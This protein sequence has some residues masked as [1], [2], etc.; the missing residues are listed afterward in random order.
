MPVGALTMEVAEDDAELLEAPLGAT[1]EE[2][3]VAVEATA[4][5]GEEK[6][7]RT[8]ATVVVSKDF[9]DDC[10]DPLDW[11]VWKRSPPP[12]RRSSSNR[13][14]VDRSKI[15]SSFRINVP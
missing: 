8:A 1:I 10:G 14:G 3:P 13:G 11:V 9:V 5:A 6:L 2:T 12:P 4:V 15:I 7:G